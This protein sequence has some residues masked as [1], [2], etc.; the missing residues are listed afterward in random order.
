MKGMRRPSWA[1][2][3]AIVRSTVLRESTLKALP[4]SRKP[5]CSRKFRIAPKGAPAHC[6]ENGAHRMWRLRT[7]SVLRTQ[8]IAR[9]D[10]CSQHSVMASCQLRLCPAVLLIRLLNA[11]KH[12]LQDVCF[13]FY[14]LCAAA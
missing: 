4:T 1:T 10:T 9:L 2:S 11:K 5:S 12:P 6:S 3:A 7:S 13:R 8:G 14:Y